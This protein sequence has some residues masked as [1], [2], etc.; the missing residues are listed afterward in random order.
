MFCLNLQVFLD[1]S[2]PVDWTNGKAFER[3]ILGSMMSLSCTP[4][5]DLGPYEFFD[6][7]SSKTKQ[8]IDATETSVQQV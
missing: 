4:K 1:C 8:D 3:T 7:P 6:N 2:A 5:T